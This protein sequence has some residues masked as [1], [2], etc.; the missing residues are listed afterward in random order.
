MLARSWPTGQTLLLTGYHA[1]LWFGFFQNSQE[2]CNCILRTCGLDSC[3]TSQENI[4]PLVPVS[5]ALWW[6]A[7]RRGGSRRAPWQNRDWPI[8]IVIQN[9]CCYA[10]NCITGT[11][12]NCILF[13][14]CCQVHYTEHRVLPQSHPYICKH[15]SFSP[16]CWLAWTTI[17]TSTDEPREKVM[18]QYSVLYCKIS[19]AF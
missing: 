1:H 2:D 19:Y 9:W 14:L 18:A 7:E 16:S 5:M 6:R 15:F 8:F 11:Q 4:Q 10:W 12:S 13:L 17:T 3:T